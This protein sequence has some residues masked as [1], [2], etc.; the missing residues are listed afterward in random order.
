ML[1]SVA[2]MIDQ[3]NI[4]NIRLLQS[5]GYQVDVAADFTDPGTITAERAKDLARRLEE[6]EVKVF[7]IA[8]PRSLS[9]QAVRSAY[10]KVRK[11]LAET[12]YDLIHC[13][14][15][16]GGAICRFAAAGERKR[17][18]KVIYTA[19]GFHFY[20]GAPLKNWIVYYPIEKALSRCTDVL[21]TI[22]REDYARAKKSFHA[23]KTLYVPGIGVDTEKIEA[24]KADGEIRRSC[25]IKDGEIMLLSVGELNDNK[26][27]ETAVR[28]LSLLP[29]RFRYV[30]VGK[31][32]KTEA[33]QTLARELGVGERVRFVGF[34]NNV[35]DYYKSADA[36][37]FPSYREGL[38]VA[39]MEAM[40]AG[41][42]VVCSR[43]RG[44]TDLIDEGKGGF[45]FAPSDSDE[46]AESIR[47]LFREDREKMGRYNREK[48]TSF[49]S[50]KVQEEMKKIYD[51]I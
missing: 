22:N 51:M 44:N 14:S 4:P 1:S 45:L 27:H 11:L 50:R 2:S 34:R 17:G 25:S 7:D 46:L 37:V 28:A 33:L 39:L 21:I 35:C 31:G 16:I 30:V 19:H 42:P 47:R 49:S 29:D 36:F 41:L 5:L 24:G 20:S 3:F 8:I 38:P 48:I 23:G 32:E 10:G 26:N 18:T 9:P 6:M 15:P 13:H 40:A 12:H 43:I